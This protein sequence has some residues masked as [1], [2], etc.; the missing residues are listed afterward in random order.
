[1]KLFTVIPFVI[2]VF[3]LV[4][5]FASGTAKASD[6][7]AT[8]VKESLS[9]G[10]VAPAFGAPDLDGTVFTISRALAGLKPDESCLA[11]VFFTTTC[12]PCK[13][14]I[15]QLVEQAP[16]LA[17]SGVQVILVAAGEN[18]AK[19]GPF[20]NKLGI[21]YRIVMDGYYEVSKLFQL[22]TP[23]M[24]VLVP[25]VYVVGRDGQIVGILDSSHKDIVPEIL[26]VCRPSMPGAR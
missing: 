4:A 11:L 1:M 2:S 22:T 14:E 21:P 7:I 8:T 18:E 26:K 17:D 10:A 25:M 19:V 9:V 6:D 15:R 20:R 24:T 3:G 16:A 5:S 13:K 23:D 12:K